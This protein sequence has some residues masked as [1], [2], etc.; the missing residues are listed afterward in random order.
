MSRQKADRRERT[1]A[2]I[3][4]VF[5]QNVRGKVPD[6]SLLNSAHDGREGDWLT[7]QMGLTVNGLNEPD[8]QGFEMKKD[9]KGKTT[10]GDW[11]P[12]QAVYKGTNKIFDRDRFLELFGASNP[13]KNN[14]YSWSGR[15]FPNVHQFNYAGQIIT[16]TEQGVQ[17]NYDPQ[18]DTRNGKRPSILESKLSLALW[19]HDSLK[20]RVESKFNQLGWFRCL[21]NSSGKYQKIVFGAPIDYEKFLELFRKG[22]IFLDCGM[23]QGNARPYMTWRAKNDV[24]EQLEEK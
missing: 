16:I 8:F 19:E 4:E 22:S 2:L 12:D 15:V 24:W 7:K 5:N 21:K 18:F 1:K 11:G 3:I 6:L 20:L 14:R 17:I 9:S 13:R 10:F 23:H